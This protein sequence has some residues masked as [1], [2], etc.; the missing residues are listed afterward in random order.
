[1]LFIFSGLPGA[2][3][4]TLARHLSNELRAVYLRI[5]T[6]EQALRE[7]GMSVVGPEG[8][9]IA[10]RVAAD[11]LRLGRAVVADS[12]NPIQLTRTAWR[13]VATASGVESIDIE[14]I[15][16]ERAEHRWRVEARKADIQGHVVP[17]WDEIEMREYHA[18]DTPPL[19]ID[20]AGQTPQESCDALMRTIRNRSR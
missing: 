5:D 6:I 12:V 2:G 8:Y 9:V 1:M 7:G 4:T 10:Y 16:S 11:N 13:E 18:W 14:V 15:C 17:T 19:V 3:K 20:T